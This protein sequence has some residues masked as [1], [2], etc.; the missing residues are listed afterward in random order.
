[1]ILFPNI[2]RIYSFS[3]FGFDF[4]LKWYALSYILGFYIRFYIMKY[5]INRDWL[6]NNKIPPVETNQL[7]SL[8]TYLILGV[9]IGGRLGYILL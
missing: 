7:D 5:L 6:W 9:I 1:M 2:S 8:M 3:F 4:A